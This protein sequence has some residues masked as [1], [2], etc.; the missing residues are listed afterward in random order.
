MDPD[1]WMCKRENIHA[2]FRHSNE[3]NQPH[4]SLKFRFAQ[5]AAREAEA[6]RLLQEKLEA[7]KKAEA[8]KSSK[9]KK[10]KK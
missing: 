6:A 2:L 8:A 3:T 4:T 1:A 5:Q 9:K 10:G 7:E